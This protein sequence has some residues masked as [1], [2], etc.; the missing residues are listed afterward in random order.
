VDAD[1]SRPRRLGWL[2]AGLVVAVLLW[3]SVAGVTL[4]LDRPVA[5]PDAIVSLASHEWERLPVAA[6]LAKRFPDALVLLTLPT[7]VGLHN[8]HNCS[9][10]IVRLTSEGT[11]GE[12]L[13]C[14]DLVSRTPIRRLLIV[15]SVYHTRR[16]LATFERAF[17]GADVALGI[18]PAWPTPPAHPLIWWLYPYDRWYVTY[19]WAGAIY[20]ALRYGVKLTVA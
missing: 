1:V 2:S 9:T 11:H 6:D 14:R 5:D 17:A 13:A 8:C 19:E 18:E 3:T 7:Q 15:T 4:I 10:R 16:A 12:A 20:Y